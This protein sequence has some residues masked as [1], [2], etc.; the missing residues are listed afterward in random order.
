MMIEFEFEF[1]KREEFDE[2][3]EFVEKKFSY[4]NSQVKCNVCEKIFQ[5]KLQ[6]RQ[7]RRVHRGKRPCTNCGKEISG[8]TD[9]STHRKD[10][11]KDYKFKCTICEFK[12]SRNYHLKDHLRKMHTVTPTMGYSCNH[13]DFIASAKVH[14]NTHV[15]KDHP[16]FPCIICGKRL[17]KAVTLERHIML[18]HDKQFPCLTCGKTFPKADTLETHIILSHDKDEIVR[19]KEGKKKTYPCSNCDY[20]A[21]RKDNLKGHQWN[22]HVREKVV[23]PKIISQCNKGCGYTSK[24]GNRNLQRHEELCQFGGVFV[25]I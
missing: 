17:K 3:K 11:M 1:V 19:R 25:L 6:L 8:A 5:H 7:H 14:L 4:P 23:K 10:C 20:V 15:S 24:W 9:M 12:T 13:C 21:D 22:N 16:K 2:K 18:S